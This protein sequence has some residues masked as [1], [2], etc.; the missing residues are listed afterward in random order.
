MIHT[1]ENYKTVSKVNLTE[2]RK[3]AVAGIKIDDFRVYVDINKKDKVDKEDNIA[4]P[5]SVVFFNENGNGAIFFTKDSISGEVKGGYIENMETIKA[6]QRSDEERKQYIEKIINPRNIAK[7]DAEMKSIQES[8]DLFA[9]AINAATNTK[10]VEI[11]SIKEFSPEEIAAVKRLVEQGKG[12]ENRLSY[13]IDE[14]NKAVMKKKEALVNTIQTIKKVKHKELNN[15]PEQKTPKKEEKLPENIAKTP[16]KRLSTEEF[17]KK[18]DNEVILRNRACR[19]FWKNMDYDKDNE[20]Q[21]SLAKI[22]RMGFSTMIT[23]ETGI[24]KTYN[25][26]DMARKNNI[27][28]TTINLHQEIEHTD[29]NGAK[30]LASNV[31]TAEMETYFMA[32]PLVRALETAIEYSKEGKGTILILDELLRVRDNSLFISGFSKVGAGEY[33]FESGESEV[34]QK[35]PTENEGSIWFRITDVEEEERR[36]FTITSSGKIYMHDNAGEFL[37]DGSKAELSERSGRGYIPSLTKNEFRKYII[38]NGILSK[39]EHKSS[40]TIYVP[41]S[42]ISVIG[43]TNIGNGY[44]VGMEADNAFARRF[45]PLNA[46]KP[47]VAYMVDIK[48]NEELKF[49]SPNEQKALKDNEKIIKNTV[50]KFFEQMD[51]KIKTVIEKD[52]DDGG[53][54][55]NFSFIGDVFQGLSGDDPLGDKDFGVIPMLEIAAKRFAPFSVDMTIEEMEDHPYV[56]SAQEIISQIKQ[57]KDFKTASNVTKKKKISAMGD[58]IPEKFNQGNSGSGMKR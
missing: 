55:V 16:L 8:V 37:F 5:A 12:D 20:M 39:G 56:S 13:I 29:L 23:G 30:E 1:L 26:I 18:A 50:R 42:S 43:T 3:A 36:P 58:E 38:G 19:S 10:D 17:R 34:F 54:K 11:T 33:I 41:A 53:Q 28:C 4:F 57:G 51:K 46:P 27:P 14:T 6:L 31:T 47:E 45:I 22:F 49:R 32:G 24:G 25:P 48:F 21:K 35:L 15:K 9:N 44:S 7:N 52:G 40:R 2:K